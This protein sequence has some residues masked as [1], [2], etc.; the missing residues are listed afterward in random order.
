MVLKRPLMCQLD[1]KYWLSIFIAS[2]KSAYALCPLG[3]IA[4][5]K[6]VYALCP[7]G[8]HAPAGLLVSQE[9][10]TCNKFFTFPSKILFFKIWYHCSDSREARH[11]SPLV[12][13]V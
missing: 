7:L 6:S 9:V 2:S 4:S 3:F 8:C 1:D 12:P 11:S 13:A 5:P 10:V